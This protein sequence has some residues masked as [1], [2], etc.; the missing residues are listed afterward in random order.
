MA[1]RQHWVYYCLLHEMVK[2]LM[3]AEQSQNLYPKYLHNIISIGFSIIYQ[4]FWEDPPFTES[5]FSSCL[6]HWP[7][8]N[9]DVAP[10]MILRIR[11]GVLKPHS[12]ARHGATFQHAMHCY[13]SRGNQTKKHDL[14]MIYSSTIKISPTKNWELTNKHGRFI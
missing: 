13:A 11:L 12:S 4:P 2:S 5:P 14:F 1:C 7:L 8:A 3:D 6:K 10:P 9:R